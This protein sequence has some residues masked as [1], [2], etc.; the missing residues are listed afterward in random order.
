MSHVLPV[1]SICTRTY[2]NESSALGAKRKVPTACTQVPNKAPLFSPC[3][4]VACRQ[5]YAILRVDYY[6]SNQQTDTMTST[7]KRKSTSTVETSKK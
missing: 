2:Q 4:R 6:L 1:A 7:R 5:N 3:L